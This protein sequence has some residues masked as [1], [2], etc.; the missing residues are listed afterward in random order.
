MKPRFFLGVALSLLGA[1]LYSLITAIIKVEHA[2]LPPLPIVIFM[3][4]A[5][6]LAF[7]VPFLFKNGAKQ[8]RAVLRSSNLPLQFVRTVSSLSLSYLIFYS[9]KF[10]PLVNS[11][12]LS[13][14]APLIV[15]LIACLFL[16]HKI[17]HRLW[18][19]MIIG[20][21]GVTV[22]LHPNARIFNWGSV[23]ALGSAVCMACSILAVR[24][25]SKTDASETTTFYFFLFSTILSSIVAFFFWQPITLQMWGIMF[26]IGGLYLLLQYST[27]YA[28]QYI[29]AQ[30]LST[31]FYANI[32]FAAIISWLIWH[33]LP[34]AMTW[35]GVVL[36]VVGGALCIRVEQQSLEQIEAPALRGLAAQS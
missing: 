33:S 31:L 18:I 36:I 4:S 35:V 10:I 21:V 11:M 3:Q 15:P 24:E 30:L 8:A 5:V 2:F 13:N 14:T 23:L 12:L 16:S 19:P 22:V 1:L 20:F 25:L 28:L 17:N 26:V 6:A 34:S 7:A 29:N 27:T 32:V 9:V